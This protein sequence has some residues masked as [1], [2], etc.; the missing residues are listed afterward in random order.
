MATNMSADERIARLERMVNKL[1][2]I[3]ADIIGGHRP[4]PSTLAWTD[5]EGWCIVDRKAVV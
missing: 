1:A 4:S 3:V 2:E 5:D